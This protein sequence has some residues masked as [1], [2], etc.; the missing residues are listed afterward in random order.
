MTEALRHL[1]E[2]EEMQRSSPPHERNGGMSWSKSFTQ[3][4]VAH[5]SS[6]PPLLPSETSARMLPEPKRCRLVEFEQGG[7]SL[8]THGG[9]HQS[10]K[11]RPSTN[12]DTEFLRMVGIAECIFDAPHYRLSDPQAPALGPY[13][14]GYR[15]TQIEM[16]WPDM[17]V[18]FAPP[19]TLRG[20]LRRF[21]DGILEATAE[22]ARRLG[23][24]LSEG[25][26][27]RQAKEIEDSFQYWMKHEM[28]DIIESYFH[29]PP[30][31]PGESPEEH[32][33]TYIQTRVDASLRTQ[34]DMGREQ[35]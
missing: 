10:G 15:P 35:G 7:G 31:R 3:A 11:R 19:K 34:M 32:F 17:P 22:A 2:S 1:A 9:F 28:E 23:Y 27:A 21:P 24:V 25:E 14:E 16:E 30:P 12:E 8:F 29:M 26:V 5:C 6:T 4:T 20:Y 18:E 13:P 33:H